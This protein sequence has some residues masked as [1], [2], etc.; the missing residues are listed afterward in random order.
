MA[1]NKLFISYRRDD[2]AGYSGRVHDR[3]QREFGGNLLFMD[4]DSIPLGVNFSKVL[5]DEVAKCDVLLAVIGPDWLDARDEKG[6]RRLDKPDDFVRI[7]IGTALKRGIPVI[8]ILLEGTRVPKADQLPDDLKELALRNGLNV[9]HASF[10]DDMERL[11]RGLKGAQSQQEPASPVPSPFDPA[12]PSRTEKAWT[13]LSNDK[14]RAVLG[15]IGG[16]IVV[17]ISALW[18]AFVYFAPPSK[19]ALPPANVVANPHISH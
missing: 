9:R 14:N 7:E 12:A 8:P 16:G 5:V 19:P 6:R 4:V 15:W 1:P 13:F 10:S 3:L 2:S 18:A 11:I 17:V